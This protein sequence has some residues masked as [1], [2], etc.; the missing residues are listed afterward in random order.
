MGQGRT[1]G[2]RKG[3]SKYTSLEPGGGAKGA[4]IVDGEVHAR[5]IRKARWT[6]LV[7]I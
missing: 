1:S 6:D 7:E 2:K 5:G 3:I 4:E